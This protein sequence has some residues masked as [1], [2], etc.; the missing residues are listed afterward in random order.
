MVVVFDSETNKNKKNVAVCRNIG[1]VRFCWLV[2]E[3]RPLLPLIVCSESCI[4]PKFSTLMWQTKACLLKS[5]RKFTSCCFFY[6]LASRYIAC[7]YPH[8]IHHALTAR[9]TPSVLRLRGFDASPF[10]GGVPKH[11]AF[12]SL[13]G[14]A[15]EHVRHPIARSLL[16]VRL[17][18]SAVWLQLRKRYATHQYCIRMRL[19]TVL[20]R[21]LEPTSRRAQLPYRGST[22]PCPHL[23]GEGIGQCVRITL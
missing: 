5:R 11:S 1:R 8:L 17:R 21:Y 4:H 20:E 7:I 19:V 6:S 2:S 12:A 13:L 10:H 23:G 18:L 14:R 22:A 9:L 3:S 15:L 16:S